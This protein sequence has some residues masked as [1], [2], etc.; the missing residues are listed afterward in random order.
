[1]FVITPLAKQS[2]L[3]SPHTQLYCIS[4]NCGRKMKQPGETDASTGETSNIL[5]MQVPIQSGCTQGKT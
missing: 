2:N 3:A 5:D 1:M 4:L